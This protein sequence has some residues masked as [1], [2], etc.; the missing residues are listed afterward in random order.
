MVK[1]LGWKDDQSL[2]LVVKSNLKQSKREFVPSLI[3]EPIEVFC[4][5]I[6][7]LHQYH[8]M[9]QMADVLKPSL[10]LDLKMFTFVF[11]VNYFNF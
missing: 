5:V 6:Q 10:K 9:E 3:L 11:K 2:R 8:Q 4:K 7:S 1:L